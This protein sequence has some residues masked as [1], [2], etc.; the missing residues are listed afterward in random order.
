MN[1]GLGMAVAWGVATGAQEDRGQVLGAGVK[2]SW[3]GS[4]EE[5][6]SCFG[7]AAWASPWRILSWDSN[8]HKALFGQL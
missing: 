5:T 6:L 3:Q 7:A 2:F 1:R 8:Q 4:M